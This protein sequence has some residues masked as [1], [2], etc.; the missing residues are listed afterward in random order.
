MSACAQ[1][2][3]ALPLDKLEPEE[4]TAR[5]QALYKQLLADAAQMPTLQRLLEG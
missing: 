2:F 3:S 5:A 1:E 4:A